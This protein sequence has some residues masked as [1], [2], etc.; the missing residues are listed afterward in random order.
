MLLLQRKNRAYPTSQ[1]KPAPKTLR[2]DDMI[3]SL[4]T[5]K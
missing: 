3:V 2:D 4:V 1:V 5:F